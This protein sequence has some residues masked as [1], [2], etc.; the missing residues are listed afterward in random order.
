MMHR[1][2]LTR[3]RP[4]PTASTRRLSNQRLGELYGLGRYATREEET[5]RMRCQGSLPSRIRTNTVRNSR[6]SGIAL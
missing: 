1:L 2:C 6:A 4:Q 3:L 5:D